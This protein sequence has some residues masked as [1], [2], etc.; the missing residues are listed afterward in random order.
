[1]EELTRRQF[2]KILGLSAAAAVRHFAGPKAV[3]AQASPDKPNILF[4]MADDHTYQAIG[5][6]GSRLTK[7]NP[8]PV[9]G[10]DE[11]LQ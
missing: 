11:P 2:M 6:Y 3:S 4:I 8:T 7:L 10:V 9:I 5:A 1:M